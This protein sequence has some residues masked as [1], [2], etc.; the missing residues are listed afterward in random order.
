MQNQTALIHKKP[1]LFIAPIIILLFSCCIPVF[2]QT[3]DSMASQISRADA[4][5]FAEVQVGKIPKSTGKEIVKTNP[6]TGQTYTEYQNIIWIGRNYFNAKAIEVLKGDRSLADIDFASDNEN[7]K[8]GKQ[9]VL[10]KRESAGAWQQ[11]G[12]YDEDYLP[13]LHCL[14]PAL[15]MKSEPDRIH[16]LIDLLQEPALKCPQS[17]WKSVVDSSNPDPGARRKAMNNPASLE[18]LNND[19]LFAIKEIR[20][21]ASLDIVT[22][23]VNAFPKSSQQALLE[24]MLSTGDLRVVSVLVN[25]LDSRDTTLSGVAARGLRRYFPGDPRVTAAFRSRWKTADKTVRSEAIEYLIKREPEPDLQKAYEELHASATTADSLWKKARQAFAEGPPAEARKYC[26]QIIQDDSMYDQNRLMLLECIGTALNRE[27]QDRYLPAISPYLERMVSARNPSATFSAIR[28]VLSVKHPAM[29]KPLIA[30]LNREDTFIIW[31]NDAFKTVMALR[32]MGDE[33]K[34]MAAR[35]LLPQIENTSGGVMEGL[36]SIQRLI[37]LAWLGN[38]RDFDKAR[39]I[40]ATKAPENCRNLLMNLKPVSQVEDEGAFWIDMIGKSPS[41]SSEIQNWFFMRL[42]KIRDARA[43]PVLLSHLEKNRQYF[44][45]ETI[46]EALLQLGEP[47]LSRLESILRGAD[48]DNYFFKKIFNALFDSQKEKAIPFLRQLV[49]ERSG[50]LPSD[51]WAPFSRYGTPEDIALL[52]PVDNYWKFGPNS[53][54]HSSL[55][56]LR[57][58]FDYDLD[59]PIEKKPH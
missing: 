35:V 47:A 34:A 14:L 38:D 9:V 53:G 6:E 36:H 20:N 27:D 21:P 40:L 32:D 8:P 2:A 33:A 10:L 39:Q 22:G 42:G 11:I 58:K 23:T 56:A 28:A 52:S 5:V 1:P 43:L 41:Q 4:V 13:K 17:A 50:D 29:T 31:R 46:C 59:G 30:Y 37:A 16:A 19:V 45:G 51:V 24:W 15:E 48:L 44:S 18:A 12:F 54:R 3:S 26:I 25:Y 49:K 57:E 7:F 55:A